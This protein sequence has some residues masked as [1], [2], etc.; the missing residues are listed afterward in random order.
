MRSRASAI[1]TEF[2][3]DGTAGLAST[4]RADRYRIANHDGYSV[5]S[6]QTASIAPQVSALASP[7]RRQGRFHFFHVYRKN[8]RIPMR[9]CATNSMR[10]PIRRVQCR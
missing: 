2:C 8:P 4:K 1:V 10:N 9:T 3:S 5:T 7:H 6:R